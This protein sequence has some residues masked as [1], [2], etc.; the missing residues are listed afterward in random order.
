LSL[1]IFRIELFYAAGHFPEGNRPLD[2][3][4]LIFSPCGELA[5]LLFGRLYTA[6]LGQIRNRHR[7]QGPRLLKHQPRLSLDQRLDVFVQTRLRSEL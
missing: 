4:S 2:S 7:A 5:F 1:E 6:I 3:A